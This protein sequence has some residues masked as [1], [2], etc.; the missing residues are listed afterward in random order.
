VRPL[1]R[2]RWTLSLIILTG[3]GACTAPPAVVPPKQPETLGIDPAQPAARDSVLALGRRQVY[4]ENIGAAAR[5]VLESA[6]DV[7][8]EPMDD[9][10]AADSA[11]LAKGVVVARFIN[12]GQDSLPRLGL[13]PGAVTY[14][15]IYRRDGQLL[16]DFIADAKDA[17]YDRSAVPTDLHIPT[18]PWRQTIAQWQLPGPVAGMGAGAT[19]LLVEAAS[20]PWISC[21]QRGCCKP[22][23]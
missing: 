13:A 15:L 12:H 18:R 1:V 4:D 3:L 8:L 21:I 5:T 2:S 11:T 19:H 20:Q 9:A 14:W 10:Y 7:T 16:S 23:S 6:I 22:S 17:H